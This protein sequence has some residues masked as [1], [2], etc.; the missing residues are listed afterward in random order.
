LTIRGIPRRYTAIQYAVFDPASSS[1]RIASAGMSGPLHVSSGACRALELSGFPPGLF[2]TATYDTF[3]LQIAPGDS[4][5]FCTDGVL[6]AQNRAG[7][8]Y[9]IERL[10]ELCGATHHSSAQQLLGRIFSAVDNFAHGAPQHDDMAATV[11]H[12]AL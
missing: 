5:V 8:S 12:Y 10:V 11:F 1:M 6:E 3:Q 4:V 9:G 2:P 7:E